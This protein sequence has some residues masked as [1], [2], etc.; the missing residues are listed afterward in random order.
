MTINVRAAAAALLGISA[1]FL[2]ASTAAAQAYAGKEEARNVRLVGFHDLA[3][4]TAYQPTIKQQGNRWIAYVG[5]P[6]SGRTEGAWSIR[7]TDSSRRT[8]PRSWM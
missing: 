2:W 3:A 4:R 7:S 1:A 6:T 8:A 5:S